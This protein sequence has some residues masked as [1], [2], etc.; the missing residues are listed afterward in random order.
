[1]GSL[2][3]KINGA[4]LAPSESSNTEGHGLTEPGH[5]FCARC[6]T[7]LVG[8]MPFC[9][10][11]GLKVAGLGDAPTDH[12]ASVA[13]PSDP[14]VAAA[15]GDQLA[16][17]GQVRALPAGP[18]QPGGGRAP[19]AR[20]IVTAGL[21]IAVGL[22][23]FGLITRPN[24][25][26][27]PQ[28]GTAGQGGQSAP[29]AT[30]VASAPI[31]GLTILSPTDGQAVGAKEVLVIG[32]APPGVTITQDVSFG[33]DQHTTVD[34]TGHWAIKVGLQDGDNKLVFRI[35][36]DASTKREVRVTYTP[37]TP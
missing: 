3:D 24:G 8:D 36:D 11:C 20:S 22:I 23:A 1:M 7:S 37:Q 19:Y 9:P 14:L 28:G 21:L 16:D 17:I 13:V 27:G 32:I 12:A 35:G 6:G 4:I 2:P 33:L 30:S 25:G 5:R 29:G 10:G 18:D 15:P 26:T 31:V 34:G